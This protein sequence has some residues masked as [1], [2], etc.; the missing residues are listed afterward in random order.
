MTLLLQSFKN[1]LKGLKYVFTPLGI[2]ALFLIIALSIAIPTIVNSIQT[3]VN[4]IISTFNGYSTDFPTV[5]AALTK[6]AASLDWSNP[7]DTIANFSDVNY[8]TNEFKT[9]LVDIFPDLKGDI[10][11]A[12]ETIKSCVLII[13]QQLLF[14]V[15]MF[16]ISIVASFIITRLIINKDITRRKWYI[17]IIFA[18]I[19]S[20]IGI[21]A[22]LLAL[23]CLKLGSW[24]I[25]LAILV[26]IV[27]SIIPFFEGYL[28]HGIKRIKFKKVFNIKNFLLIFLANIILIFLGVGVTY[29]IS[30]ANLIVL[31]TVMGVTIFI[32]TISVIESNAEGYVAYM[33]NEGLLKEK[34]KEE[35]VQKKQ[36][37]AS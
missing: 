30:L 29:L 28:I 7:G 19:D 13:T 5:L 11:S 24:G 25:L 6:W 35:K 21:L 3:M 37:K 20:I 22:L 10:S 23:K 32:I 4:D 14:I 9:I 1:F 15:V 27:Y 12:T 34:L 8:L 2:I 36:N 33:A 18:I 31:T 16:L 17:A 26:F